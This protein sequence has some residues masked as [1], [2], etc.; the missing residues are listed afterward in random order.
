LST[1]IYYFTGTGNSLWAARTLVEKLDDVTLTPMVLAMAEGETSPVEDRV[2]LVF[3]VYMYRMPHI[4]VKF[5]GRLQTRAPVSVVVTM[6]GATGD[7]FSGMKRL[8]DERGL[9][10]TYTARV[11]MQSNYIPFGGA[12][13]DDR[14]AEGFRGAEARM[15]AIA[16]E[17][18]RGVER[19]DLD[20]AFF[21]AKVH[22]GMLYKLGYKYAAVTDK[23][24]RVSDACDGC[25]IC[26]LVCP[27]DNLVMAD[28]RPT[29][30][31]RCEQCMAC[32]QWCPQEAIDVKTKTQG[33]RRYQHPQVKSKDIV[34]QKKR[35]K[36]RAK[37]A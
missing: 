23:S 28:D 37:K 2:V 20:H 24:Y 11:K 25:G 32:L 17:I 36:S 3:P 10:L 22:P 34:A 8:F 16:D 35:K 15:D 5:V 31:Q 9:K 4:V 14:L 33:L 19:I 30:N 7:L 29:W 18:G 27:V 21:S 26:A 13:D 12:P 6:G 1:H